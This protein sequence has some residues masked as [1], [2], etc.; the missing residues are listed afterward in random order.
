MAVNL[1]TVS[2]INRVVLYRG[3]PGTGSAT[4]YT[5]PAS[6]DAKI[7]SFIFCNTTVAAATITIAVVNS[8]AVTGADKQIFSG[9]SIPANSTTVVDSLVFMNTGDFITALQG[10]ASAITVTISG[11]TY[12]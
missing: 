9:Q 7:A 12:A 11:E 1:T 2:T 8:G 5:V 3:Q 10:T 4:V 6:T